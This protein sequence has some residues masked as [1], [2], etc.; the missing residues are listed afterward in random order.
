MS[1]RS[2]FRRAA[3]DDVRSARNWYEGRRPGLGAAFVQRLEACIAQI[4]RNPEI[5][6][7]GDEDTRRVQLRRFPYVVY[8]ELYEDDILVLAVWHGRRDP[9][10][11]KERGT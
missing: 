6:P 10:G 7:V 8:Y 11:R 1:Q 9:E 2:V 4:E 5:G 3:R